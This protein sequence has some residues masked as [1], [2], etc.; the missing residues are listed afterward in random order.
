MKELKTLNNGKINIQDSRNVL[1]LP[2]TYTLNFVFLGDIINSILKI[3]KDKNNKEI[4]DFSFELGNVPIFNISSGEYVNINLKDVPISLKYYESWFRQNVLNKNMQS[5]S[6]QFYLKS[7]CSSLIYS[8]LNKIRFQNSSP[9]RPRLSYVT[10]YGKKSRKNKINQNHFIYSGGFGSDTLKGVKTVDETKNI[11]HL[12]VG[13]S[14]GLVKNIKFSRTDLPGLREARIDSSR[15]LSNRSLLFS[16]FYKS[17]IS[18]FGNTIFKPGMIVYINTTAIGLAPTGENT[19]RIGLSGY[20]NVI[21]TENI[22]ES[23][24]FETNLELMSLG[25]KEN[26][27]KI[28]AKITSERQTL[29][30]ISDDPNVK[31]ALGIGRQKSIE[32]GEKRAA[33][34]REDLKAQG[35][36]PKS[37]QIIKRQGFSRTQ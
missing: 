18:L 29:E 23:G 14:Q 35:L 16:D 33:E 30:K 19:K 8:V 15:Q 31:K 21:K 9:V 34:V 1:P 2:G 28:G 3:Y 12:Y 24:K 26:F 36:D 25:N 5:L 27:Q 32:E 22:I 37:K 20:Y 10:T 13:A 6:L 17:N 11:F 7:L 4:D